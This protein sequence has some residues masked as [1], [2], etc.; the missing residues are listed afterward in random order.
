MKELIIIGISKFA[1]LL[2]FYLN[3][4]GPQKVAAF[5][6]ERDYISLGQIIAGRPVVALETLEQEFPPEKFDVIMGVGYKGMNQTRRRLFGIC[7]EKGYH[8]SSFI[9]PTAIISPDVVLGEGNI[10]LEGSLIQP[11]VRLGDRNL[12]WYH[13]NIAHNNTIGSF[14]TMAGGTSLSGEVSIANY[15]FLGNNCT[16]RNQVN[17]ADFTLIGAGA[18]IQKDT[19]PYDVVVPEHSVWL[20]GKKSTDFI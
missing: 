19:S 15:C 14:N 7:K 3:E 11:F 5:A 18:Y 17:L 13:V 9:H 4:Y 6:A 1:E 8:I 10:I 12:I 20:N 2:Y 16:V